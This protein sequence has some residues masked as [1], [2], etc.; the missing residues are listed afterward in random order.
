MDR[1]LRIFRF[2]QPLRPQVTWGD[3]VVLLGLAAFIYGAVRLGMDAPAVVQG[4]EI[5]LAP[6]FLPHYAG[7]SLGRMFAA[8]LLSILFSLVF[9]YVASR[10]AGAERILIPLFDVL[11]S[12]PILSFLPVALLTFSAILP[13]GVAVE[14]SS[15]VLIFTSQAWN[16][17]FAWYQSLTTIPR[18][19]QR[20]S[21]M[22]RFNA[23]LRFKTLELPFAGVSLIWNS[24]ASWAGGWFFLMAAE[25]FSA[26]ERNFRLPGLGAYLQEAANQGDLRAIAYGL[27]ALI[28]I[29]VI[30]DQLVWRPLIAWSNR[31]TMQMVSSDDPPTS[32]FYNVLRNA[33]SVQFVHRALH[34]PLMERLDAWLIRVLPARGAI[35]GPPRSRAWLRVGLGFAI[36]AVILGGVY[37]CG[38]MLLGVSLTQ[39]GQIAVGLGMT[40]L[41]VLASLA[42]ALG[43]TIPAGVLIGTSPR[44]SAWLQPL[45]QI[46]ASIPATALFPILLLLVV[47]LPGGLNLAAVLLMLLGT[48]W[49]LLFNIIAGASAIPRDLQS[50]AS[51]LQLRRWE[52]WRVLI[53]PAIFPYTVTGALAASGGAWN[54]SVVA[55]YTQFG[56][57][58]LQTTGV[59]ALIAEAT[60]QGDYPLLLAATLSL[61]LTVIIINR[62]VWRRLYRLAEERYRL[63]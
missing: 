30:L 28:L 45:A 44:L 15:I 58:T 7:L 23:W 24:M 47:N 54:A 3:V 14:L 6:G 53:L 2:G 17:A 11:Q 22:L 5:N 51:L 1:I 55:E 41:R 21:V 8:Y 26:G 42:I 12:I 33:A 4:P 61:I 38:R 37:L 16:L 56:G 32:W 59:G 19:L 27:T 36:L 63:D 52:R 49:Y 35:G 62:L 60:A 34:R 39:W 18:T 48:Q 13:L 25:I 46:A 40:L 57:R 10:S 20:A 9:G 31:F 29:I 50:I 43:W